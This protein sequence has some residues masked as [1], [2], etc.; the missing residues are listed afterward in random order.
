MEGL[1]I[2]ER[3]FL[4]IGVRLQI[5]ECEKQIH[6]YDHDVRKIYEDKK[7]GLYELW[8]KLEINH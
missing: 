4:I 5:D 1:T 8:K 7:K 2:E 6:N 3:K